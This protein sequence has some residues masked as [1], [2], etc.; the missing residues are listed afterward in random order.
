V[1]HTRKS[2]TVRWLFLK[3]GWRSILFDFM[4]VIAIWT[5]V[6]VFT[7]QRR[8]RVAADPS[9]TRIRGYC[10]HTAAL[11]SVAVVTWMFLEYIGFKAS[12]VPFQPFAGVEE[13]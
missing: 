5:V 4:T 13:A 10:L 2:G 1:A 8:R 11:I 6:L 12:R 7:R 9:P 3:M